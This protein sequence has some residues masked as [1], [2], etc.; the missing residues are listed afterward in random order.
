MII[1]DK[2]NKFMK[3]IGIFGFGNM[4][5]AI[6]K[7]LKSEKQYNFFIND[8]KKI[9]IKNAI[10]KNNLI[11]LINSSDLIF[12]CI[13]PQDFKRIK[14]IDAKNKIIISIMAGINLKTLNTKFRN[15]KVIRTMPNLTLQIGKGIIAWYFL[16]SNFQKKEISEIK[17]ILSVFGRLIPLKREKDIHS[18]TAITGCGPAYV[19]VFIN[20]LIKSAVSLGFTKKEAQTLVIDT[21]Q[22]S[23]E[24][25]KR[26]NI[27]LENLINKVASK[28]GITEKALQVLN[29]KKFYNIWQKSII[30]AQKRSIELSKLTN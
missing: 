3:N 20:A 15:A 1:K 17:N 16:K 8:L 21:I 4:G 27:N 30:A 13:K 14:I 7:L 6:F 9:K 11:D 26:E 25:Y 12:I 18:L 29:T 24:Y 22:G 28:K 5:Q 19:F 23:L 10:F 2:Y